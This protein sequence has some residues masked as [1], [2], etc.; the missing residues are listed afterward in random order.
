[1]N[2]PNPTLSS[3]NE[4]HM[5]GHGFY[6]K[7]SHEQGKANTYGLPLLVEAV[8]GIDFGQIG[9]EFRIADYG[10]AQGQN[11]LL[12][13]K[14]VI[15]ETKKRAGDSGRTAIPISVTHTD[16]PTNDWATLFQTV[17]FSSDSYLAGVH[18]VFCF[19]SG[20]SIY[21]QI[22]P[23]N[24]IALGYSAI[25]THWLSRKPCN[26]PNEIWSV[27]ATGSIHDTWA[28]HAK[29]DWNAFLQY[30]AIE[31]QPSAQLVII[32]SGADA[33]GT[34]GAEGLIDLANSV[35]QHLV[36]EGTLHPDE[37]E[38]MAIP[39]YYRTT[40]EWKAPLTPGSDFMEASGLSL[41]HFEERVLADT[42]FEQYQQ[43][44]DA[45]AFAEAYT[46][47]FKAAFEP[48][49]FAGLLDNR[50]PQRRQDVIDS[51]SQG[52]QSGLAQDPEKYSCRWFLQLMVI[53]KKSSAAN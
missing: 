5:L 38:Q 25:T 16:L 6:N 13:M 41:I 48:C 39:T 7:H 10:S 34:S 47:F 11:S 45:K 17:L 2:P 32:A 23:P 33:Q 40:Q 21:H 53:A 12:P 15:A 36:K 44:R 35:L 9:D 24:H 3:H 51:F 49:L 18:D 30:R 42:Y 8:N 26:I 31:M 14:T 37:Y 29:A 22:F 20:T 43:N 27:R 28:K 1:M 50:T 4:E 46:G 52:L 19:A